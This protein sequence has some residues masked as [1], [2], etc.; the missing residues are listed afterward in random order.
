MYAF[1]FFTKKFDFSWTFFGNIL[2]SLLVGSLLYKFNLWR[3]GDAK[4]FF[5]Y[6]LLLPLNDYVPLVPFSCMVLFLNTFLVAFISIVFFL[7]VSYILIKRDAFIKEFV[8]G[9]ILENFIKAFIMTYCLSTFFYPALTHLNFANDIL[10]VGIFYFSAYFL[11]RRVLKFFKQTLSHYLIMALSL[12][13]GYYISPHSFSIS[14]FL[15]RIVNLIVFTLLFYTI[16]CVIRAAKGYTER[17]PF[18]PFMFI[19]ALLSLTDFLWWFLKIL[20]HRSL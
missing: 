19:G 14:I 20:G 5:T 8:R 6:S 18:A 15:G 9:G 3:G 7:I 13:V 2:V 1:L 11:A 16:S 12:A 4:L 17:I 10:T